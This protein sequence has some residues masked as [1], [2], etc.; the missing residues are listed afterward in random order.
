MITTWVLRQVELSHGRAAIKKKKDARCLN[1]EL[2]L[3]DA[4]IKQ[5]PSGRV[6]HIKQ[7]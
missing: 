1:T 2:C 5:V 3:D 6:N 4:I 7:W